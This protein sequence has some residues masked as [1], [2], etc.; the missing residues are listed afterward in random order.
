MEKVVVEMKSSDWVCIHGKLAM[1][2]KK[3]ERSS[4]C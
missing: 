1:K 2:R 4:D 3:L